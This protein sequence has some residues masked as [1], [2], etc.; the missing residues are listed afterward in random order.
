MTLAE[1][2]LAGSPTA[3][4]Y[5]DCMNENEPS[6]NRLRE[7]IREVLV[8]Q[9]ELH[10]AGHHLSAT[11]QTPPKQ[12]P[13]RR[14]DGGDR[15]VEV[16]AAVPPPVTPMAHTVSDIYKCLHQSTF[17]VGHSIDS[18]QDF[19]RRLIHELM[20]PQA[21]F[22]EPLMEKVSPD[23]A[24]L[25]V[26]LRP[27]R[28]LFM[29][30]EERGCELLLQVCLESADMETGSPA[31]FF[32]SL[33]LFRDLNKSCELT[34]GGMI[35]SFAEH[36][37]NGFLLEIRKLTASSGFIPVLSHSPVYKSFNDPSYRVVHLNALMRSPLA[38]LI[39]A[40]RN[41]ETGYVH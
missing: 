39:Q 22:T 32:S 40:P 16:A 25:R 31:G 12:A 37:V 24:V 21:A 11:K 30:S 41:I 17:G 2:T 5:D 1:R 23:G 15:P 6:L 18:P 27:F 9:Y 38:A 10:E 7:G 8:L 35:F 14:A 20:R 28:A 34:A 29:G 19:K 4:K 36:I 26:N 13:A 33:E 3:L